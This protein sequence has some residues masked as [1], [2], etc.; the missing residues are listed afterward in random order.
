MEFDNPCTFEY[1]TTILLFDSHLYFFSL[2]PD[3]T[4][5][6]EGLLSEARWLLDTGLLPNSNSAT[7]AIGYRQVY[8][9][10]LSWYFIIWLARTWTFTCS[11]NVVVSVWYRLLAD[12]A[13]MVI[14]IWFIWF[15]NFRPWN[16]Y[17]CAGSKVV[18]VLL[19]SFMDFYL[20]SK[21]HLGNSSPFRIVYKM[22]SKLVL[23][24]Y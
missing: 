2:W 16:I 14:F 7:R 18:G 3:L 1:Q 13:V 8:L 9:I 20:I 19:E 4:V 5:G 12:G 11:F 22:N 17:W 10:I 24:A 21:K 23:M 15:I 6:G